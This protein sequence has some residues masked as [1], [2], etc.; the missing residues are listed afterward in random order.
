[1]WRRSVVAVGHSFRAYPPFAFATQKPYRYRFLG[2]GVDCLV[3][4]VTCHAPK[5]FIEKKLSSPTAKVVKFTQFRWIPTTT[6]KAGAFTQKRFL[7]HGIDTGF[8]LTLLGYLSKWF[9]CGFH[10]GFSSP[11]PIKSATPI[12]PSSQWCGLVMVTGIPNRVQLLVIMASFTASMQ[13]RSQP[14]VELLILP[15]L[16][17]LYSIRHSLIS[18]TF[19]FRVRWWL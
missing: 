17:H 15:H 5:P 6:R 8:T 4:G 16:R 12:P 9:S 19:S 3:A 7:S 13:F 2:I 11:H 10:V 14:P 1:M 18:P